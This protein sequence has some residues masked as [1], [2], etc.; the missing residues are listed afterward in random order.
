MVTNS[1]TEKRQR[2][3]IVIPRKTAVSVPWSD[4]G[5]RTFGIGRRRPDVGGRTFAVWTLSSGQVSDV[6]TDAIVDVV[7][8]VGG[9]NV[10]WS[11][12]ETD[13]SGRTKWDTEQWM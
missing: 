6:G 1:V 7:S 3:I 9:R 5:G 10:K 12:V 8:D 11:D 4:V 13:D 2:P